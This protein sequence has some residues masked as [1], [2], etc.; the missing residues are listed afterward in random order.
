MKNK[1]KIWLIIIYTINY[2]VNNLL[3]IIN[4]EYFSKKN[5]VLNIT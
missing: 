2:T 3:P 1:C 5:V 4:I